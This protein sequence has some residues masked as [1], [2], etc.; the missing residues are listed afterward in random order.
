MP[1]L[2][3]LERKILFRFTRG[4]AI[5][6]IALVFLGL[7]GLGGYML[8]HQSS[9]STKDVSAKE[10]IS[11]LKAAKGGVEGIAGI[12][13]GADGG[14]VSS[15]DPLSNLKVPLPVQEILD[16]DRS[17]REFFN[18]RLR[19]MDRGERQAYLNNL[20][21]VWFEAKKEGLTMVET[22]VA[23]EK[24]RMEL[25]AEA[26]RAEVEA[27]AS[28]TLFQWYALAALF[29]IAQFSLVLVLLAIERNTRIT[30]N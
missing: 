6:L 21:A 9:G 25:A 29:L 5:A 13:N 18:E 30:D 28:R 1:L 15:L 20:G 23:F 12:A 14:G 19:P 7:M 24:A 17:S 3:S 8:L 26:S 10:L 27:K 2:T 22:V 16:T 11:K 4:L